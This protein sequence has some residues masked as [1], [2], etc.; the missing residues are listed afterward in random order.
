MYRKISDFITDWQYETESTEKVFSLL[1]DETLHNNVHPEVRTLGRLAWH[2]T[3]TLPE[4]GHKAGLFAEDPLEDKEIPALSEIIST[5]RKYAEEVS[6]AAAKWSDAELTDMVDMYG[7]QWSKGSVLR[8][9]VTHQT[10]HRGQMT[11]LMRMLGLT[12]PGIYGPSKEEWVG[13]GMTAP[14]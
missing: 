9:F 14:A 1:T 11:V 12:V 3:Q 5:Y 10:H 13:F 8:V 4:M 7:D 6:K 2:L